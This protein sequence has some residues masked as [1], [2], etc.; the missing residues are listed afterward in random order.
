MQ[1]SKLTKWYHFRRL[2]GQF[3]LAEY[4]CLPS[5]INVLSSLG[6]ESIFSMVVL[7]IPS[8]INLE[9]GISHLHPKPGD[10][11]RIPHQKLYCAQGNHPNLGANEGSCSKSLSTLGRRASSAVAWSTTSF[12][13]SSKALDFDNTRRK[14]RYTK[15]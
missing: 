2:E 6:W 10:K 3:W 15:Y 8:R 13:Q 11:F 9:N 1:R 4:D 14:A 7:G 12:S 5:I